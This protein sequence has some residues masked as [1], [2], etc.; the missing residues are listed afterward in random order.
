MAKRWTPDDEV[1]TREVVGRRLFELPEL[2]GT[3]GQPS[4]SGIRMNHFEDGRDEKLSLDRL[5][6][7]NIEIKVVNYLTPRAR[8][9]GEKFH[10]QKKFSGWAWNAAGKVR[11]SNDF[12]C[13]LVI[14]SSPLNATGGDNLSENLYHAH[15]IRPPGKNPHEMA[16]IM[17]YFLVEIGKIYQVESPVNSSVLLRIL[18]TIFVFFGIH[19]K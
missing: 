16:L 9:A 8:H 3:A 11:E 18:Q 15:V 1:G 17:R 14:E 19:R 13:K 12:D 7:A 2:K 10:K 5:G 6:R 4:F